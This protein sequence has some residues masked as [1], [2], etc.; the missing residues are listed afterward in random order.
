MLPK[1][2]LLKGVAHG[3]IHSFISRNNDIGG[4]WGIGKLYNYMADRQLDVLELD[5]LTDNFTAETEAFEV[6]VRFFEAH[7]YRHLRAIELSPALVLSTQITIKRF[8]DQ[9]KQTWGRLL[10]HRMQCEIHLEDDLGK[11]FTQEANVWCRP[12]DPAKELKSGRTTP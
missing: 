8:P 5:L 12:H 3:L 10:P 7:L 4:Y 6:M 9:P 1:R 11:R 2:R